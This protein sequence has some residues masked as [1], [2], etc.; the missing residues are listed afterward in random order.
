MLN[1]NVDITY[2]K[3]GTILLNIVTSE[4]KTETIAITE[5]QRALLLGI[6]IPEN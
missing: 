2:D 5:V 6:N 3:N 1:I 4:G